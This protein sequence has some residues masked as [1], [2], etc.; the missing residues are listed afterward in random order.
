MARAMKGTLVLCL[1]L[2]LS[3]IAW[4]QGQQRPPSKDSSLLGPFLSSPDV[5][6]ELKLS[7][8]QISKLKDAIGKVVEKYQADMGNLQRMSLEDRQK[9]I[10]AYTEDSNK[11]IAG[12]L[13]AKQWKR[14][15][16]LQWQL[17]DGWSLLDSDLRKE[18][19]LSDEQK[20]KIDG[21]LNG[22]QRKS[23]EMLKGGETSREKYQALY[24]DAGK[25]AK[26][27]LTEEQQKNFKELKGPP[28]QA[29]SAPKGGR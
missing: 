11:A 21:I 8:E 18:L 16:Q 2:G 12:V 23:D 26:E 15:K 28:F 20:K 3:S 27:V 14:F 6:K 25:R 1:A 7:D 24:L 9:K 22:A 10:K 5:Q 13:D 17:G 29:F 19:K 4:G